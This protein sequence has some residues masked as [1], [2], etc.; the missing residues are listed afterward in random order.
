MLATRARCF[1]FSYPMQ[2]STSAS[3]MIGVDSPVTVFSLILSGIVVRSL[4][5]KSSLRRT[6]TSTPILLS[7]MITTQVLLIFPG[8]VQLLPLVKLL[9]FT[10]L[11]VLFLPTSTSPKVLVVFSFPVHFVEEIFILQSLK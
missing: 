2:I 3:L 8:I 5:L 1:I 7:I 9:I 11:E 10:S 4:G 6:E